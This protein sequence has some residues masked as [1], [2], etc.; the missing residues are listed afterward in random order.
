MFFCRHPESV[1]QAFRAD[2][3][4]MSGK[5]SGPVFD[6]LT[7]SIQWSR[8]FIGLKLFMSLAHGGESGLAA[9]IEHQARMGDV[10]R[11][12]L[13]GSGWRIVNNTP[14]PVVCFTRDGLVIRE[15][16]A[17]LRAGQIAWMSEAP[18]AGKMVVRA[19]I[20]SFKTTESEIHWVVEEMNRIVSQTDAQSAPLP[21][22]A[23]ARVI[24]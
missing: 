18:I 24:L 9:M 17:S 10:L 16:L 14:F 5:K 8:R 21:E 20:T 6:P 2:V 15:L 23:F 13:Q 19:C 11:E 3:T 4:Y 7:A 12:A 1:A 22:D